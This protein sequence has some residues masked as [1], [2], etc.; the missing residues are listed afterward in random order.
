MNVSIT[1]DREKLERGIAAVRKIR[2]DRRI[3]IKCNKI[4]RNCRICYEEEGD[5]FSPCVCVGSHGLVHRACL[6]KWRLRFSSNHS[7]RIFC[8]IC[9]CE[10]NYQLNSP[11]EPHDEVR[12]PSSSFITLSVMI[13]VMTTI[14]ITSIF[15]ITVTVGA[16]RVLFYNIPR[17]T[18]IVVAHINSISLPV[19]SRVIRNSRAS[20]A[21]RYGGDTRLWLAFGSVLIGLTWFFDTFN[22]I[23]TYAVYGVSMV[24]N[25]GYISGFFLGLD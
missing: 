4:E 18:T 1:K 14:N 16:Y 17:I 25:V 7:R 2:E 24:L 13:V 21:L 6:D 11:R 22:Y 23:G 12:A 10:Y 19:A 20:H 15:L 3:R 9:M 5:L 8:E